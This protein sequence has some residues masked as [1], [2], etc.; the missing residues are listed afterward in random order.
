MYLNIYEFCQAYGGPE[1]GGWWYTCKELIECTPVTNVSRAEKQVEFLN[2]R[3]KSVKSDYSMG[4]GDHDGA[5]LEGNGD[6]SY[7]MV[8]GRWGNSDM[9]A[10]L[11]KTPGKN[12]PT[13][14][15]YYD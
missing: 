13:E 2:N 14:R 7:L 8:G 12:S 4:M 6:D 10:V 15:P 5:D 3:F 9:R 1:E 11:E